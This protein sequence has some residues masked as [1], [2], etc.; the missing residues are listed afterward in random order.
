MSR[1]AQNRREQRE[2]NR[3]CATASDL[4]QLDRHCRKLP[5]DFPGNQA[6]QRSS[7]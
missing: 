7:G 3:A 2:A 4:E 1:R 5:H 6:R